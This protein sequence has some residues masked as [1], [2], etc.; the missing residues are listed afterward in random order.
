MRQRKTQDSKPY[1][2]HFMV[3]NIG[4][5][6]KRSKTVYKIEGL[7]LGLGVEVQ[8]L[9]FKTATSGLRQQLKILMT[10]H[11]N[12]LAILKFTP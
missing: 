12:G 10:C 9:R 4:I 11:R 3:W 6:D 2:I 1:S 5:M 8:G 7:D